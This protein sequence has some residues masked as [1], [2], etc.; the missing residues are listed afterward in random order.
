MNSLTLHNVSICLAERK[1]LDLSAEATADCPLTIMGPSGSGK[2]SLLAWL[3]GFLA[4]AFTASGE[5]RLDGEIVTEKPA[6]ERRLGLLFQDPLLFPH[7][8]VAQNLLF[9]LPP[10][11]TKKQRHAQV[12]T[13]LD[14]VELSGLDNRDPA[15]LSGGQQARV[16]LMR[17]LLSAPKA[18]LLDEPFSKLDTGLRDATRKL[19]FETARSEGLPTIL[20]THD[21]DDARAAGGRVL[22]L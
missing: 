10:G 14:R 11:G 8:S 19:V 20:V 21:E 17:V 1:L 5:A 9:A 2:S 18:L 15:T 3:G 4:P 16:A 22:R 6:A 7:M 13:A 12:K